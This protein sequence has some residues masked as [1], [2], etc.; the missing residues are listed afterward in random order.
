M[1]RND[2]KVGVWDVC[3]F[4]GVL[5]WALIVSSPPGC[6]RGTPK[7]GEIIKCGLLQY[8]FKSTP[9]E[10]LISKARTFALIGMTINVF[11]WVAA[12]FTSWNEPMSLAQLKSPTK[13]GNSIWSYNLQWVDVP[14]MPGCQID[15]LYSCPAGY[16]Q[17]HE[18]S[19]MLNIQ[20]PD[21]PAGGDWRRVYW[22]S[23]ITSRLQITN[24]LQTN[25][26]S[27]KSTVF[28]GTYRE[29]M[30]NFYDELSA[31]WRVRFFHPVV[32]VKDML[33]HARTIPP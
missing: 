28:H 13:A 26:A 16:I 14:R 27:W 2:D 21:S 31:Y 4:V 7:L 6:L 30:V 20:V 29:Q 23:K 18:R 1:A 3:T 5:W 10:E 22:S 32:V 33:C 19:L 11:F 12:P 17:V 9:W 8:V 15:V 25:V 24:Q